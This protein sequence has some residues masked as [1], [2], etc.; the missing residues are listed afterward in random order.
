MSASNAIQNEQGL[1]ELTPRQ[2]TAANARAHRKQ[3]FTPDGLERLRAAAVENKP[4][5]RSTGPTSAS[6]KA[7]SSRNAWKGGCRTRI[8][9]LRMR[10]M[11]LSQ[12]LQALDLDAAQAEVQSAITRMR[13]RRATPQAVDELVD[14]V[15]E[16][17]D[18]LP[19]L[20]MQVHDM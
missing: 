3:G 19:K 5:T 20:G 12:W 14:E 7:R 13:L 2:R 15:G 10:R 17:P 18:P 4:W 6:G 11:D 1:V 16:T 9:L 8:E